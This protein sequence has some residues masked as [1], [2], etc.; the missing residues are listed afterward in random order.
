M[1]DGR[2]CH[3]HLHTPS[4]TL[5]FP[6]FCGALA[7]PQLFT[8]G[9]YSQSP[10]TPLGVFLCGSL[11]LSLPLPLSL[12][13]RFAKTSPARSGC[14]FQIL[15]P[16]RFGKT[17]AGV[18]AAAWMESF[19][20]YLEPVA[21]IALDVKD[22]VSE[23]QSSILAGTLHTHLAGFADPKL[24]PRRILI[25]G[26]WVFSFSL[27]QVGR[28]RRSRRSRRCEG[29]VHPQ[30]WLP[31]GFLL[32]S[33]CMNE[34]TAA[35]VYKRLD[36]DREGAGRYAAGGMYPSESVCRSWGMGHTRA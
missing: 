30:R 16:N 21:Q 17:M 6:C 5:S 29:S 7:F 3:K 14:R 34:E 15:L 18:D 32:F 13:P 1:P 10:A 20:E 24:L 19:K 35:V 2:R 22:K 26:R 27:R 4:H 31:Q 36:S 28:E 11:S 25:V 23:K 8:P 9:S 12:S 33:G